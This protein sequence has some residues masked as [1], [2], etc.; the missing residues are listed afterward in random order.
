VCAVGG[1]RFL[2]RSRRQPT[3]AE[4]ARAEGE[5]PLGGLLRHLPPETP[6]TLEGVARAL[7]AREGVLS[8][9]EAILLFLHQ[10]DELYVREHRP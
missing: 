3:V 1:E 5:T 2:A 8:E 7:L 6:F 4:A 9:P 10:F